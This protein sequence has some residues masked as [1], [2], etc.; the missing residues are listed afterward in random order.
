MKKPVLIIVVLATVLALAAIGVE[1]KKYRDE[2]RQDA[3][4][5]ESVDQQVDMLK[6]QNP[7]AFEG[8]KG[9]DAEAKYRQKIEEQVRFNA[10]LREEADKAGQQASTAEIDGAIAQVSAAY[11]SDQKFT[12]ALKSRGMTLEDYKVS[13]GNQITT[14]KMMAWLTK[15]IK[16]TDAEIREYYDA[17][18]TKFKKPYKEVSGEI[19]SLLR[20]Q[21]Q[22]K[23]YNDFIDGLKK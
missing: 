20:S 6:K 11:G 3:L 5:E 13:I 17:N 8:A 2:G 19:T 15:D 12:A 14:S 21:K 1:L 22:N 10:A 18:K 4:V 16:V 9:K 23:A 7:Q